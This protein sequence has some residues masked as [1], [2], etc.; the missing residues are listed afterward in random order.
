MVRQK[1]VDPV[2]D[3]CLGAMRADGLVPESRG[4]P[5]YWAVTAGKLVFVM[6]RSDRLA[7][8]RSKQ[9]KFL[10]QASRAGALCYRYT[11]EGG[12]EP[13]GHSFQWTTW[14]PPKVPK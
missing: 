13:V 6:V 5:D 12:F 14:G 7:R 9:L 8:L 2:K 10:Q 11:T 1:R 3:A 4:Y